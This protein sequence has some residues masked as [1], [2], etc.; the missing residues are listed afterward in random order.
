MAREGGGG[1]R[2]IDEFLSR[3]TILR[4]ANPS[5]ADYFCEGR[6]C[7]LLIPHVCSLSGQSLD[8]PLALRSSRSDD[9]IS[10]PAAAEIRPVYASSCT[11]PREPRMSSLPIGGGHT[12]VHGVP[13]FEIVWNIDILLMLYPLGRV[14]FQPHR[15]LI[16]PNPARPRRYYLEEARAVNANGTIIVTSKHLNIGGDNP[17]QHFRDNIRTVT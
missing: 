10:G 16:P 5:Q 1:G 14:W 6:R 4:L 8:S 13:W 9:Q 17:S 11:I 3:G 2:C 12:R 15:G 7:C